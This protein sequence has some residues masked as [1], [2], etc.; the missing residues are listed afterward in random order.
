MGSG[1]FRK[2]IDDIKQWT[3]HH[4]TAFW[5]TFFLYGSFHVSRK[6]FSNVKDRMGKSLTPEPNVTFPLQQWEKEH[7]FVDLKHANVFLGNLDLSFFLAYAFGLFLSGWICDRVNLRIM[8]TVG[9]FGSAVCTWCFGYLSAVLE[10]RN[11]A[12]YIGFFFLNG[13]IQSAGRPA[14]VAV[15]GKWFPKS[16]SGLV[17]GVW[18]CCGSAGN[19][20][21]AVLVASVIEYGYEYGMLMVSLFSLCA[22]IICFVCLIIH[23][24]HVYLSNPDD[25]TQSDI[26]LENIENGDAEKKEKGVET[27]IVN[28]GATFEGTRNISTSKVPLTDTVITP[29]PIR[30][31]EA[32]LIPGVLTYALA[33]AC[34]KMVNYAFLFWLPTFLAQGLHIDDKT[35][36]NLSNLYDVGGMLGGIFAGVVSD[37]IGYRAPVVTIMLSLSLASVYM[38]QNLATSMT[39]NIFLMI[40]TGFL[41]GGPA[42]TISATIAADLGKHKKLKRN[43]AALGTV[44]GIVEGTGSVGAAIGQRYVAIIQREFGWKYVFYTLIITTGMSIAL[45]LPILIKEVRKIVKTYLKRLEEA[46]TIIR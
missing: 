28:G 10:I 44:T 30:F 37:F 24:K 3:W 39:S 34:L 40:L 4:G 46:R 1:G 11:Q 38:Y 22:G 20:V 5:L 45:I 16:S 14:A 26:P 43:S 32:V 6:A 17:F 25:P 36:D 7:M 2:L 42:N 13:L 8:L 12:F 21:G 33:N 23:P 35:S 19:I 29:N 9:L 41:L 18:S 31:Y 15:M 27:G